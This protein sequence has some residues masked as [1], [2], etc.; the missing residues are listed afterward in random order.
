MMCEPS[1]ASAGVVVCRVKPPEPS[2]N[3]PPS[4]WSGV[5]RYR[6]IASLGLNPLPV[7]VSLEPAGPD[8]SLRLT[9]PWLVG[10]GTG[11][12]AGVG[13]GAGEWGGEGDGSGGCCAGAAATAANQTRVSATATDDLLILIF[14][15]CRH[16][17]GRGVLPLGAVAAGLCSIPAARAP[18]RPI[19]GEAAPNLAAASPSGGGGAQPARGDC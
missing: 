15:F 12:G 13:V 17:T 8:A 5:S 7:T 14:I 9:L 10:V 6:P 18:T 1:A 4:P 11:V 3:R 16:S 19:R 2:A